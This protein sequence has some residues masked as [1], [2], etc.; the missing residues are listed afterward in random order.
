MTYLGTK[1]ILFEDNNNKIADIIQYDLQS[2]TIFFTF[3]IKLIVIKA[4]DILVRGIQ[5]AEI[6]YDFFKCSEIYMHYGRKT[7]STL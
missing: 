1:N 5:L 2:K 7:Y 3:Y 4:I 6:S